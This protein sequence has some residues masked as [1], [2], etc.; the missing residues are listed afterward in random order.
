MKTGKTETNKLRVT[1][2]ESA[3]QIFIHNS[4]SAAVCIKD[5]PNMSQAVGTD[6]IRDTI[7]AAIYDIP[8]AN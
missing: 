8:G 7:Y 4:V 5:S 6:R 3:C 2:W 1:P